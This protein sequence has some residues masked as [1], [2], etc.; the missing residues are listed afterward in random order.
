MTQ[1]PLTW[2]SGSCSLSPA[3]KDTV[4]ISTQVATAQCMF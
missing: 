4:C 2:D 3:N 1:E